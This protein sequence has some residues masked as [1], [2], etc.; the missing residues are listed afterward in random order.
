MSSVPATGMSAAAIER[1]AA[2]GVVTGAGNG[3]AM[4]RLPWRGEK[5]LPKR[6]SRNAGEDQQQHAEMHPTG[7]VHVDLLPRLER[8]ILSSKRT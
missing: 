2:R 4:R 6:K 3:L 7:R 5:H 8:Q 1:A